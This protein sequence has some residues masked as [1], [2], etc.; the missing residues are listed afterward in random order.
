MNPRLITIFWTS[1]MT[2]ASFDRR[3]H[4]KT[5]QLCAAAARALA[6]ALAGLG[7]EALRDLTVASVEPAPDD[8][9]LLVTLVPSGPPPGPAAAAAPGGPPP[10]G[11][12]RTLA[13]L[14]KARGR[15]RA[16]LAAAICRK[17]APHLAF[18]LGI[19]EGG[20]RNNE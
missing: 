14:E 13:A 9:R 4:R 6:L 12:A 5:Q 1:L 11:A 15:L 8:S 20:E 17:R 3:Q 7:D 19:A 16:E 18:R 2:P 10:P